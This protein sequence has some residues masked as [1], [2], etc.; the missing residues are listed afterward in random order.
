MTTITAPGVT[1]AGTAPT[2]HAAH[3]VL[4]VVKLQLA[5]PVDD[6]RARRG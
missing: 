3:R 2:A 4:N 6:D 1:T 5:Q